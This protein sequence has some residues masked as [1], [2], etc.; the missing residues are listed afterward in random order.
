M[1]VIAP[2]TVAL[3]APGNDAGCLTV[4][5]GPEVAPGR[6]AS[7]FQLRVAAGGSGMAALLIANPQGYT[8]RVDLGAS[9]GKTATNSGDTYPVVPVGTCARTSCWVRDFPAEV[10][11]PAH[12]RA[13][14]PFKVVVPE[15]AAPGEYLAGVLV[16]PALPSP[17]TSPRHGEVG[18]V[19]RTSVGIGVAVVV[20]GPLKPLIT[21]PSVTLVVDGV[22]P[23]L[24]IVEH[25]GGNTWEH[26]AGGAVI[27]RPGAHPAKFGVSSSTVLPGDSATLTL[28]V[29]GAPRGP[30][31]TT[32][33]LWYAHDTKKAVW[34]GVLSYPKST[35]PAGTHGARPGGRH[36][37]RDAGLGRVPGGGPRG[38]G[39]CSRRAALYRPGQATWGRRRRRS[40][41]PPGPFVGMP[42][43]RRGI[44]VGAVVLGYIASDPAMASASVS[45]VQKSPLATGSGTS[46]TAT[47]PAGTTSGDLLVATIEDLNSGCSSDSFSA[48][49][50]WVQAAKACQQATGPLELWYDP[51][52]PSGTTSVV[53]G[54]GSTGANT[55][56]QL[57][58]WRGLSTSSPLD[59]TGTYTSGSSSTA[60]TVSTSGTLTATAE[61]AISAFD[62][63]SG[64]GSYT[65]GTGWTSLRNDSPGGFD[66]DYL[67]A[68]AEGSVLSE[69]VYQQ[70]EDV[71]G[72]R[73]RHV[74]AGVHRRAPHRRNFS[75]R[76]F[77]PGHAQ[78][79]Q[80]EHFVGDSVHAG[81]RI[82]QWQWLGPKRHVHHAVER[83]QYAPHHRHDHHCRLGFGRV[84]QLQ[85]AHQLDLL[86]RHAPRR[87]YAAD[88]R[89]PVRRRREHGRRPDHS[90]AHG[91]GDAAR[92]RPGGL[93]Q[94]DLGI[95]DGE[96]A[97]N[98]A[99]RVT[100]RTGYE[101]PV[102]ERSTAP[103]VPAVPSP[104]VTRTGIAR[105]GSSTST[106]SELKG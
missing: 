3:A 86:P 1:A 53:F 60:L 79:L 13:R 15:E 35:A 31:P 24:E 80:H 14:V 39:P 30:S 32:V 102:M 10:T 18:A 50:G 96:R 38:G 97:V 105:P 5:V 27:G 6:T 72:G 64:I 29:V 93:L 19:I 70:P 7:Y 22:T 84:R 66:S 42:R 103:A 2:G 95:V 41:S 87:R 11:L 57:S 16:Q 49:A 25:N 77:W 58:E 36:K 75:Q 23:L 21:V 73:D 62:V 26:P 101:V 71:L 91:P 40:G 48:P 59:R 46:V 89:G 9:Y 28:P 100:G 51:D 76:H 67:L 52:V 78:R 20:P 54:T 55:V 104:I 8:C 83:Q 99:R 37:L 90:D 92:R 106:T 45:L 88:S 17:S 43:L 85:F 98:A 34:Q 74:P 12:S 47:L 69:S 94:L 61:L 82:R 63:S 4:H 44:A 68:P 81:R 33:V 65:P 56:A